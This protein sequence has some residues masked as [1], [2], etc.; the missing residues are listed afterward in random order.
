MKIYTKTGDK[1]ETGIIG[2]RIKKNSITIN[3]IGTFDELNASIGVI[4]S[5]T[6]NPNSQYLQ[7]LIKIQ[8]TIFCIGSIV[9]GADIECDFSKYTKELEKNI[10]LMN[11]KLIELTKF[12]LPGG[13]T[14]SAHIHV[15][16]TICRRA[17]RQL[18]DYINEYPSEKP[19][20]TKINFEKLLEIQIYINRLSDYLF[21]LA[22][23]V[24]SENGIEDIYWNKSID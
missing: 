16:R 17:E 11:S 10:D 3:T 23:Y 7:S 6:T 5:F 8:N 4:T 21:V 22:R 12:I 13:S 1:G 14:L 15:S 18:I 2:G 19:K 20:S 9:S 24:N